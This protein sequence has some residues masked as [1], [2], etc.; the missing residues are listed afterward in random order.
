MNGLPLEG[1]R[2]LVTRPRSRSESLCDGI[3]AAGGQAVVIPAIE[4]EESSDRAGLDRAIE[5]IQDYDWL[6]F[7]SASAVEAFYSRLAAIDGAEGA[8]T[9]RRAA[10]ARARVAAIGP[11]TELAL[12]ERGVAVSSVPRVFVSGA[13]AECLGEVAGTRILIPV[14]DIARKNLGEELRAR[15]AHVDEVQAYVTAPAD[16]EAEALGEIGRGFDAVLFASPSAA[17]NFSARSGGPES[18]RGALVACIGPATAEEARGCGYDVGL[19][20][21]VHSAEGLVDA[22]VRHYQETAAATTVAQ[23][24]AASRNGQHTKEDEHGRQSRDR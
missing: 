20:A 11:A 19:V 5:A 18:V 2:I 22:L 21:E 3:R 8:G 1:R 24:S 17:R 7:T 23:G 10:L 12:R 15:G 14:S 9:E 13:V 6:V 16:F 4:I